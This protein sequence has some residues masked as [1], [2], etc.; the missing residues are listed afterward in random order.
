MN[1]MIELIQSHR[2]IRKFTNEKVSNEQI[3]MIVE[4]GRWAP[5]SH[6]VQAYSI[7]VINEKEKKRN[8]AS[9][10]G[11]QSYVESCPVFFVICADFYRLHEVSTLLNKPFEVGEIEQVLVGAVDAALVAQNMLLAARANGMGGV[12]IGGIRNEP[13]KVANLLNLPKYT[14]PVMGLCIGYPDQD[15]AQKPRLPLKAVVHDEQYNTVQLNQV[16][17]EYD[18]VMSDYYRKRTKG[19]R[20]ETWTSQMAN[21]FTTPKRPQVGEFLKN[22]GFLKKE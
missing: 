7:V 5:S 11:N 20:I 4:A 13:E 6:H 10:A 3:N 9:L 15:P 22:Q 17:R 21:H 16:L 19:K 14:F 18:D 12:M 2:S 8:L 1:T